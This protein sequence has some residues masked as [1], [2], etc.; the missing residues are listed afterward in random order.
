MHTPHIAFVSSLV[1]AGSSLFFGSAGAKGAD[2]KSPLAIR[3]VE[4]WSGVFGGRETDFQFAVSSTDKAEVCGSWSMTAEGRVIARRETM[5]TVERDKP[6]M[7][8]VRFELPAAREGI[9]LPIDL[10]ISVQAGQE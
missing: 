9:V 3:A 4:D 7:M 1:V 6:G 10:T 8:V 2:D 5:L